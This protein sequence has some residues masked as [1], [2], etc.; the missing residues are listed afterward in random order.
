MRLR[1]GLDILEGCVDGWQVPEIPSEEYLRKIAVL[2]GLSYD[3]VLALAKKTFSRPTTLDRDAHD[4]FIWAIKNAIREK[5][6]SENKSHL[7]Q[8]VPAEEAP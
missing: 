1:R 3:E 5:Q 7:E 8:E 2:A 6:S 4:E